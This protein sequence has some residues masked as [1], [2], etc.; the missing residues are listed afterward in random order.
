[1]TLWL[2]ERCLFD[3]KKSKIVIIGPQVDYDLQIFKSCSQK[4]QISYIKWDYFGFTI[5]KYG[6]SDDSSCKLLKKYEPF[7]IWHVKYT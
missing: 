4:Q 2:S 7:E 3:V 6:S 5:L 1:M